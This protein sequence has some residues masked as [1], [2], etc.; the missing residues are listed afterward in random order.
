MIN[1]ELKLLTVL[2]KAFV[3]FSRRFAFRFIIK[4]HCYNP[5]AHFDYL[6]IL[7]FF[8]GKHSDSAREWPYFVIQE[9]ENQRNTVHHKQLWNGPNASEKIGH[10]VHMSGLIEVYRSMS[11]QTCCY[12]RFSSICSKLNLWRHWS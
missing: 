9:R 8:F 5:T 12:R 11:I 7:H 3:P 4:L 1:L 2:A 6:F 10:V